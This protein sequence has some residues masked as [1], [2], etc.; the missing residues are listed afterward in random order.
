MDLLKLHGMMPSMHAAEQVDV[1][2]FNPFCLH[3][4]PQDV[5]AA[6]IPQKLQVNSLT[7]LRMVGF[8][9]KGDE[10]YALIALAMG[11]VMEI[12]VGMVIGKEYGVV[13]AV[14]HNKVILMTPDR[15]R[16]ELRMGLDN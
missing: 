10:R 13:Q 9:Q 3:A 8:L 5:W 16:V 14:R 2:V 6:Q 12:T 1:S 7:Q 11:D 4:N 15:H